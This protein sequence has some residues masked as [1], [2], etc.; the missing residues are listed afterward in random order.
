ML[1]TAAIKDGFAHVPPI[2]PGV[3]LGVTFDQRIPATRRIEDTEPFR[4]PAGLARKVPAIP[5]KIKGFP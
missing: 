5:V 1:R 2:Y 4:T 3:L